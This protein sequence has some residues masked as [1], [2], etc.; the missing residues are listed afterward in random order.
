[1]WSVE[2]LKQVRR[3]FEMMSMLYLHKTNTKG[4]CSNLPVMGSFY[5]FNRRYNY[6]QAKRSVL[7]TE[8]F[9]FAK[10]V[11]GLIFTLNISNP[12]A[13]S[14]EK[15]RAKRFG[16][17]A[18]DRRGYTILHRKAVFGVSLEN[19]ATKNRNKFS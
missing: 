6:N 12:A 5:I 19:P 9:C 15:R 2:I 4:D 16:R 1:M 17:P 8:L 11:V 13:G 10:G 3:L 7:D 14:V 18:C